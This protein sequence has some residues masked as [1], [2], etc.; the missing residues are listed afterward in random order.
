MPRH[1]GP[2]SST[3]SGANGGHEC[4]ADNATAR[5]DQA[6]PNLDGRSPGDLSPLVRLIEADTNP[7][8]R[9]ASLHQL[10]TCG[11]SPASEADALIAWIDGACVDELPHA[12]IRQA[13]ARH[14]DRQAKAASNHPQSN[15]Q[16]NPAHVTDRSLS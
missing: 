7:T 9:L 16:S 10:A 4:I 14:L 13:I 3:H 2:D 6:T 8:R 15:P 11:L 5:E 12:A 1:D